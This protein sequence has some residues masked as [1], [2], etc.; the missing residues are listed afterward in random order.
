M[1]KLMVGS[2]YDPELIPRLHEL[3]STFDEVTVAEV[4]GSIRGLKVFGSARPDFRIPSISLESFFEQVANYRDVGIRVNYTENTP[5]IDKAKTY[6][7]EIIPRLKLLKEAGVTRLTL[8]HTLAMDIV[9][10]HS[11]LSVEVSTI[12]DIKSVYQLRELKN[13]CPNINKVCVGVGKN[14]D[15][16]WLR[17]F[18]H[19]ADELGVE[20]ELLANEFCVTDCVDRVQCYNDHAQIST[21]QEA[22]QFQ[23]YPMG[24]CINTRMA[25]IEWLR[26]RF[27]LP[28]WMSW[29]A[30]N[31]G[32]TSFK[33]TGRTHPTDYIVWVTK[34]YMKMNYHDNLLQLWADV[35][36]IKRVSKGQKQ[37]L[38]PVS[39]IHSDQIP[40]DLL[41]KY[42][43]EDRMQDIDFELETLK[44][45]L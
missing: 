7:S 18:K 38:P 27:I 12:Y 4:Y 41:W 37:F 42:W 9:A 24:R 17:H 39:F 16:R 28:Q 14:R 13:R 11:D 15:F 6:T 8:A 40:E 3:N 30:K 29:Y 35:R 23:R 2:N 44:Q 22:S 34:Q 33:V 19:A 25:P 21:E 45:Y 31:L 20:V 36:N 5:L 43:Q 26:A 10:E 1:I 32:I